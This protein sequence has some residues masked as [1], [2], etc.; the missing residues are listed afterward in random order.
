MKYSREYISDLNKIQKVIPNLASINNSK[1]LVTG[2]GGLIGSAIIDFF[3]QY[4]DS[5]DAQ[6]QLCLAA[7]DIS[8]IKER[9]GIQFQRDDFNFFE[10]DAT[11]PLIMEEEFDYIIHGA[12][13]AN[14]VKYVKQPVETMLANL[15]GINNL[16]E[17][18]KKHPVKRV[19]YISSSE[20]YGKKDDNQPYKEDD[21]GFVDILN[22]RACYPSAKRASET[23]CVAYG[24]EYGVET[25]IVRPG[26]VYGPTATRSD[27]RAA[28]QFLHDV[29][30]DQDIIM[31]SEGLQKRSYCYVLDCVSAIIT[32]LINGASGKAYNISNPDSVAT[33]SELAE[34]FAK[35]GGKKVIYE[36][37][38]EIERAGYNLMDNSSL[39]D[40]QLDALGWKGLFD[41]SQGVLATLDFFR[42]VI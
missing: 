10:Y 17:Y 29:L 23:L 41:L 4:N 26:H 13:N 12:S 15:T 31:K 35:A 1:I 25:V 28:S 11:K 33:I 37:P 20:V 34:C 39:D 14:P 38:T 19:L 36:I 3:M 40:K 21:Y 5:Y 24:E 6:I 18:A 9:F 16:L 8:N 27:S 2:A 22:P 42:G 32:V 7:R 30:A